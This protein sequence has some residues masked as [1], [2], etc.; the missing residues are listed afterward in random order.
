MT[1]HQ[2]APLTDRAGVR[3]EHDALESYGGSDQRAIEQSRTRAIFLDA[4]EE[5]LTAGQAM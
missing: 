2:G 3:F 1:G 4:I 5:Q